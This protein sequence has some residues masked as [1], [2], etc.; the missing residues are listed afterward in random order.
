MNTRTSRSAAIRSRQHRLLPAAARL[1]LVAGFAAAVVAGC[2]RTSDSSRAVE[3][4]SRQLGAVG[5]LNQVP[6]GQP[7]DSE[8]KKVQSSLQ[9]VSQ[10]GTDSEKANAALLAAQSIIGQAENASASLRDLELAYRNHIRGIT[11]A[12]SDWSYRSSV[13]AAAEALDTSADLAQIASSKTAKERALAGERQRLEQVR[14]QIDALNAQAATRLTAADAKATEYATLMQQ[15]VGMT[16]TQ[17]AEVVERANV[18]RREGDAYRLEGSKIKAQADIQQ[19][20]VSEVQLLIQELENQIRNLDATAAALQRRQQAAR[21]EASQARQ[22]ANLAA[23]DADRLVNEAQTQR[24]GALADS[25]RQT[26]DLFASAAR[27]AG[28]AQNFSPAASKSLIG[29]GQLSV[30]EVNWSHAQGWLSYAGVLESLTAASPRLPQHADYTSKA[31]QARAQASELLARANEALE[32]AH[33][34]YGSPRPRGGSLSPE[35]AARIERLKASIDAARAMTGGGSVDLSPGAEPATPDSPPAQTPGAEPEVA[36]AVDAELLAAADAFIAANLRR[37][38]SA[39]LEMTYLPDENL[40]P[41]LSTMMGMGSSFMRADEACKTR[42][43]K[44][45]GEVVSLIPQIGPMLAQSFE[46]LKQSGLEALAGVKAADIPF[47]VSGDRATAMISGLP[48]P[49]AFIRSNG[50]WM[51]DGSELAAIAPMVGPM[52]EQMKPL[53]SVVEAW[54]IDIEA[55]KFETAQAAAMNF[56]QKAMPIF[57]QMM[58]GPG[59]GPGGGG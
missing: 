3:S 20:V 49:L 44:D 57:M 14:A 40:R 45:A 11:S 48:T 53:Q 50:R 58:G 4:A 17:A 29:L 10:S 5:T 27:Q 31:Q 22:A 42:F 1:A 25:Y 35:T 12:L 7:L 41:L 8:L 55:G 30:A 39:L 52:M 15:T 36:S 16:A 26:A 46:G 43:Q 34:A 37:D 28:A 51:T 32:A 2:D 13:A 9:T 47:N 33:T 19:P 24:S 6:G 23:N 38:T 56:Q 54:A 21:N 18:I 59:G